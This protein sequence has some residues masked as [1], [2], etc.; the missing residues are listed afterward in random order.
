M[1]DIIQFFT[2]NGYTLELTAS[3]AIFAYF[4]KHRSLILLR[5]LFAYAV[6]LTFSILWNRFGVEKNIITQIIKYLTFFFIAALGVFFCV[7][8]NGWG[9]M[10]C[11]TGGIATQHCAFKC[12][13]IV[14]ALTG[15]GYD[16]LYGA[17]LNICVIAIYIIVLCIFYKPLRGITD[18]DILSTANLLIAVVVIVFTIF[19]QFL[20]EEYIDMAKEPVK[21]AL[22]SGYSIICCLFALCSQYWA[23]RSKKL[24]NDN[25]ILEH[26][27][28]SQEEQFRN[29][30]A[31]IEMVNIKCHD[32]KHKLSVL[33]N[34]V[35]S[36]ELEDI[37]SVISVYDA[38]IK[39]GNE[40][41]D[42]VLAEKSLVCERNGIKFD[43][44][45]DGESL[46]FMSTSD[47]CALFGNAMD[48]AIEA[49]CKIPNREKR[50]MGITVRKKAGMVT[51]HSENYFFGG[52]KY[53][54]GLPV[55]T[56]DNNGYHG[57]G[58]RSIKLIAEK[59]KGNMSIR[60][61]NNVFNLNI[62]I[63]LPAAG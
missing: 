51:I 22:V 24:D 25:A 60:I 5:L 36:K 16:S 58:L 49:L 52:L 55:T 17:L 43:H 18:N 31:N 57:F 46:S 42:V 63:P 50:V 20:V 27:L 14:L 12:I 4:F 2:D 33:Q 54:D 61:E 48:N 6:M 1:A 44:M 53:D 62:I 56:K 21:Y 39:T 40:V 29:S 8:S 41:L 32:M 35:D 15:N 23:T 19:L 13:S 59:Y 10:F 28:H 26:L 30:K 34:K 9:V 38:S 45:I 47:I 3:V 11:M 37:K 7:K